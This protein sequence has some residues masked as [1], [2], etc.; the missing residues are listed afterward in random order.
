MRVRFSTIC[1]IL[2]F[3][4]AIT[5]PVWAWGPATHIGLGSSILGELCLLPAGVAWILRRHAAAF[6]FGNIAAD[7]VFAKRWSRVKQFCHH[8]PT[9]F[10]LL[11]QAADDQASAFA[12]GY[13][14]HLAADTVAHGKFVPRQIVVSG[15]RINFGHLYWELRADGLESDDT[16]RLLKNLLADDL[17]HHHDALAPH[18]TDTFLPYP[19]NRMLFH[20][21]NNLVVK[22]QFRRS[23]ERLRL[24]SRWPLSAPLMSAYR[25]ECVDRIL[26]VLSEGTRSS[27]LREDPNGT[28]ALMELRI[29]RRELR[30][31]RRR[32]LI[33]SHRLRETSLGFEPVTRGLERTVTNDR[34]PTHQ[35]GD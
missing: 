6:L 29:R 22:P 28:S 24:S 14:S 18:I 23:M 7:V 20:R 9:G 32:G 4:G 19:M 16:W 31:L 27:L 17:R 30:R 15:S 26:S 34:V 5:E 1:L 8:W 35:S 13:L 2:L 11:D 33:T 12:Y 25:G 21:V 10:R 3:A